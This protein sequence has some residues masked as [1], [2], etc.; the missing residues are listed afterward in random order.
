MTDTVISATTSIGVVL[1]DDDTLTVI[2]GGIAIGTVVSNN[3]YE[4]VSSGGVA[5]DTVVSNGGYVFVGSGGTTSFTTVSNG[6]YEFVSSGGTAD[7]TVVSGGGTQI[8]VSG[9]MAS[10]TVVDNRGSA[11][12]SAA[13]TVSDTTVGSGGGEFV[14]SGGVANGTT[15]ASGGA[16]LIASSGTASG[17]VVGSGGDEIVS[18]HGSAVG[19]VV[20]NGGTELVYSGGNVTGSIVNPGGAIDLRG[21]AFDNGGTAILDSA[22]DILTVTE[23]AGTYTQQLVGD[24]SDDYFTLASDNNG[25]T[26]VTEQ[27]TPCYCRGTRIRTPGGEV[28]VEALKIGDR[29]V[30][31]DGNILPIKWI[32]R[33]NYRDWSAVGN[34]DVQPICFKAGSIADHVPV[35]DLYVSPEHAMALDGMLV[36]ACHLVNDVS[37]VKVEGMEE[38]EYFHLEFDRHVVIFAEGAAAESF[39]DD[40]SRMLFHNADEYRHLYPNESRGRYAVFCAPRVEGGYAL[41]ALRRRLM[42]RA[43]RLLPGGTATAT[44]PLRGYL[45]RVSRTMVE[46]WAFTPNG[47]GPVR[48]AILANGVVV[49]QVTADRYRAD[50]KAAGIG[51]GRHGFRFV[52]REGFAGDL[53]HCIEVRR[54]SDWSALPGTRI[55]TP[56]HDRDAMPVSVFDNE[57]IEKTGLR[58]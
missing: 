11:I 2:S 35:R 10:G 36:P 37:I 40:D 31:A 42:S 57:P 50:L 55:L 16:Q 14:F 5:S 43:M 44:P 28:A 22:T 33:R 8:I 15:V 49:S 46:G 32:G 7:G 1:Q 26:L 19:T 24:Y 52:L 23:S 53:S 3:A 54:E 51:D 30:T 21:I 9:G 58:A 48:L 41:D 20:S 27:M 12:V 17:T 13:G 47:D 56:R 29:I 45:D 38:I 34:A 39:V 18:A 25:G 4:Y 6:G